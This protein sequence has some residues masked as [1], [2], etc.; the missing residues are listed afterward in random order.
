[1]LTDS[2]PGDLDTFSADIPIVNQT[3]FVA[4]KTQNEEGEW[5][6]L[7]NNDFWPQRKTWLPI[8]FNIP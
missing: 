2:L 8:I 1:V 3:V 6:R 7:S 4:L 5:S